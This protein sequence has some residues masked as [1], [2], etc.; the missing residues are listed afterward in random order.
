MIFETLNENVMLI[1][2]TCDEMKKFHIT[3]DT[4]NDSNENTQIALKRLLQKVDADDRVSKGEKVVVEALPIE[5]G[6]CFFI[7]TFTNPVKKRYRVK[8]NNFS[9]IFKAECLNDFLDFISAAKNSINTEQKCYAYEMENN[10]YLFI[11]KSDDKINAVISEFGII[12]NN[13]DYERLKEYGKSLGEIY[14]Q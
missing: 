9:L 3:Y 13:T 10:F 8:K 6:G 4:L 11:P 1:E 12:S 5:N 7:I 2:L 14:L